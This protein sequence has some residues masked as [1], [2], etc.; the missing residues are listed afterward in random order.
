MKFLD[1]LESSSKDKQ[2]KFINLLYLYGSSDTEQSSY[3]IKI[4]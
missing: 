4:S 3:F 2:D 1:V